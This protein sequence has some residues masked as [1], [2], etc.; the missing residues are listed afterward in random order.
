M[1]NETIELRQV[2]LGGPMG[3]EDIAAIAPGLTTAIDSVRD[4]RD[5][6]AQPHTHVGQKVDLFAPSAWSSNIGIFLSLGEN[7]KLG[8]SMVKLS[9]NGRRVLSSYVA[10]Y[11]LE[12]TQ[13]LVRIITFYLCYITALAVFQVVTFDPDMTI[14]EA[15]M[16]PEH[17]Q[18]FFGQMIHSLG[19]YLLMSVGSFLVLGSATRLGRMGAL[20]ELSSVQGYHFMFVHAGGESAEFCGS[21]ASALSTEGKHVWMDI[22][23]LENAVNASHALWDAANRS[24]YIVLHITPEFLELPT[25]CVGLYAALERG[26]QETII[27]VDQQ[28]E[29]VGDTHT[30]LVNCLKSEGLQITT[31]PE[32]LIMAIDMVMMCADD[33]VSRWWRAHAISPSFGLTPGFISTRVNLCRE[34]RYSLSGKFFLPDK[35]IITGLHYITSEGTEMGPMF[36]IPGPAIISVAVIIWGIY[37]FIEP[38]LENRPPYIT[39]W[40][41]FMAL[42]MSATRSLIRC[43]DC[44]F[45]HSACLLPLLLAKDELLRCNC[46]VVFVS[47]C[48]RMEVMFEFLAT[49]GM[50]PT[51]QR[52]GQGGAIQPNTFYVFYLET[53]EDGV[54]YL[55][56][57]AGQACDCQLLSLSSSIF[58]VEECPCRELEK[59]KAIQDDECFASELLEALGNKLTVFLHSREMHSD[60]I[61]ITGDT[62]HS[63]DTDSP[64]VTEASISEDITDVNKS[65]TEEPLEP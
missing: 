22:Y 8:N 25:C 3:G 6:G 28:A 10:Y 57:F 31:S 34:Q 5:V 29:W 48:N 32:E 54:Q 21:L 30:R 44:R 42:T 45:G 36:F 61:M 39:L 58:D 35:A 17:Y 27:F 65:S 9:S 18:L 49:L 11:Y 12:F 23:H 47:N 46:E 15:E 16:A 40:M 64:D 37:S 43:S 13:A 50:H 56:N 4:F 60:T 7:L 24:A 26:T 33:H 1:E 53:P 2:T 20:N 14:E 55:Q 63:F 62:D 38:F 41:F 59:Y 19:A 51:T 52:L